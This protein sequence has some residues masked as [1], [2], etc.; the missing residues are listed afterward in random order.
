MIYVIVGALIIG[1]CLGL[2]GSGGSILT[3]PVLLYLLHHEDKV[4]IAESLGIV[5]GI[6]LLSA[7]P[8]A[9]SRLIDWR[10]V[11]LF[12]VP[13][14]I[15]TYG[16][17]WLAKFV[18]GIV[19][20]LLFALVMLAAALMM[21]R[22]GGATPEVPPTPRRRSV[23]IIGFEGLVVGVLTGF[24]GVGGGFLIV[25]A[26]VILGGLSMRLAVGTSL[27]IIALKSASGFY[28]YLHVLEDLDLGIEWDTIG[29]FILIGALGSVAGRW[30]NARVNQAALQRGFAVF[31]VA[32]SI[33]IL[34]REGAAWFR[35]D[36]PASPATAGRPEP[37]PPAPLIDYATNHIAY[38]STEHR[39]PTP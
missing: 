23:A 28:K 18:P 32:M 6:A 21:W 7:V 20:L 31:L 8:Y 10:T 13:G 1:A 35:G 2:F 27:V 38:R 19:Q 39:R 29:W 16:G 17:A 22:R 9:K 14:M 15:G 4:A 3:V 5:G 25:P 11:L 30:L 37:S 12:G 24:V 26:L 33:F 36:P 34:G